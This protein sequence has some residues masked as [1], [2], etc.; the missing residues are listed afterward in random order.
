MKKKKRGKV[1]SLKQWLANGGNI[2]DLENKPNFNVSG[3]VAGM[4]KLYYG[5]TCD[6]V[7]YDGYYYRVNE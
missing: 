3:S 7:K 6:I 2:S 5:Y 1:Y 4:R